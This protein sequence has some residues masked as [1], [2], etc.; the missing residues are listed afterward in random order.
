MFRCGTSLLRTVQHA[1]SSSTRTLLLGRTYA[2]E[3]TQSTIHSGRLNASGDASSLFKTYK[4]VTPGLRHLRRPRNDHVYEGKPLRDLTVA[5]RKNGGRNNRGR[6][7]V[8]HIGGGHKQRIRLV[9]FLRLAP[10]VQDVVRIEF[11]PGRSAHIALL[12]SRDPNAGAKKFTYILAPEGLRAGDTVQSFRAGIP[13]DLAPEYAELAQ[14]AQAPAEYGDQP[15]PAST[16]ISTDMSLAMGLLRSLTI[17]PGNVLPIKLIPPG[18][19]IHNISLKPEGRGILVRSAGSFGTIV[20]HAEGDRYAQVRLQS[21]EI[22]KVLQDCVAT[23]GQVSNPLWQ[24]RSLG[25]AGRSRWLGRRP[26]VRGVA[27]N[28]V[29]HP[30]GGGRGKSKSNKHPVSIWGWQTKGKRTRKSGPKGPKNSNKMVIQERPRG[31]EKRG[32]RS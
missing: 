5:R 14:E 31:K 18:T 10:G 30:H 25:K 23:I 29:D 16:A 2:T 8:R 9:D 12:Q 20:A 7:T 26:K 6:I 17:K 21:G 19:Q 24:D 28:A 11:D 3:A 4:P 13:A 1:T 22:R 15:A 32:D 27:M